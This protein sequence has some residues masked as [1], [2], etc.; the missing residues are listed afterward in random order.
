MVMKDEAVKLAQSFVINDLGYEL[1]LLN[2]QHVDQDMLRERLARPSLAAS[3]TEQEAILSE[4]TD[5][6][7][8]SFMM[9]MPD[10]T[11]LDSPVV[12]RVEDDSKTVGWLSESTGSAIS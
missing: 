3:E 1:D 5:Y 6:W 12:V 10:G 9:K 2:V 7:A 11:T 4:H 8:V